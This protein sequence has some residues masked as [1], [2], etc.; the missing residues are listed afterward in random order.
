MTKQRL[1]YI[2]FMKGL[3]I[4]LIVMHHTEV[5]FFDTLAPNL[6]NALQS[7]RVP[8]Y[9]F[10][11]GLF[12]KT[13]S[14]FFSFLK[15]KINN[16]IIPFLFFHIIGFIVAAATHYAI[17]N[18]SPFNWYA[19]IWPAYYRIWPYTMPLWFLISLFE[20][21]IIYYLLKKLLPPIGNIIIIFTISLLPIFLAN[22]EITLPLLFDTSFVGL[23]FFALGTIIKSSGWLNPNKYDKLGFLVFIP[24]VI[25]VYLYAGHIDIVEQNFPSYLQLFI[26]PMAAILALMWLC[27]NL[28]WWQYNE[29]GV[30]T[31]TL[32]TR[33]PIIGYWGQFSLIVLGT[34]DWLLTPLDALLAS[35]QL[36]II[37]L[38]LIK[39]GITMTA[40][41]I[42]IPILV[43]FF[44]KF[45]AQKPLIPID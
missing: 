25:I 30:K 12:F 37:P 38:S 27:K 40:M 43:R 21:N 22:H 6:D 24:V 16:L 41:F 20:V 19:I 13:Y 33:I 1:A 11:S 29:D 28:R 3:C 4:M 10:L 14:G 45:T 17:N 32:Y 23:P 18:D 5:K 31:N 15:R 9:Y 36:S 2:D 34:H 35:S 39:W 8:M 7:F 42:I 44:P 26:V